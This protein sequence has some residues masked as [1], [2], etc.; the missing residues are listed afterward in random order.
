MKKLLIVDD[1]EQNLYMLQVLLSAKV[2]KWYKHRTA[3]KLWI[4]RGWRP[5]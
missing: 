1:N 2:F 3:P 4:R 5:N